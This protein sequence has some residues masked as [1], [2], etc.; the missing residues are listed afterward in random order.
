VKQIFSFVMAAVVATL[1]S[2]P[3]TAGTD[4]RSNPLDEDAAL[5]LL[6]RTLKHDGV[7]ADRISLDCVIYSTEETTR[8]YFEFV[9]RENHSEKCGG[10]P[11]VSPAVDRYRVYRRSGR[12]EWLEKIEGNWQRYNPAKIK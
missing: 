9:L 10:D 7:Y 8:A 1:I 11:E 5:T 2:S 6:E 12:I 3:V 4:S